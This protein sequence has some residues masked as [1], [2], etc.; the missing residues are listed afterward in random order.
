[1][2]MDED[3]QSMVDRNGRELSEISRGPYKVFELKEAD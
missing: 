1:M 2:A 3:E